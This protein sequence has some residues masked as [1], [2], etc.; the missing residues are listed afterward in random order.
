LQIFIG[1]SDTLIEIVHSVYRHLVAEMTRRATSHKIDPYGFIT[2][3]HVL[4]ITLWEIIRIWFVA[5]V[6]VELKTRLIVDRLSVKLQLNRHS[7]VIIHRSTARPLNQIGRVAPKSYSVTSDCKTLA[8][9]Q[10]WI[11]S[12]ILERIA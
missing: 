7:A 5:G 6:E 10:E 3:P 2:E 12:R 9:L 1:K 4:P 11:E 8:A